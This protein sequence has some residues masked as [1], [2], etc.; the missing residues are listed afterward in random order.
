MLNTIETFPD[1]IIAYLQQADQ[2]PVKLSKIAVDLGAE[3]KLVEFWAEF[4]EAQGLLSIDYP[5]NVMASPKVSLIVKNQEEDER[6]VEP[7]ENKSLVQEYTIDCD[8]LQSQ[9]MI[10]KS[11]SQDVSQYQLITPQLGIGTRAL[12]DGLV[13]RLT[14]T[15]SV[16]L[17]EATDPKKIQKLK[18]DYFDLILSLLKETLPEENQAV[19]DALASILYHRV[20]GLGIID[21]ILSDDYIEEIAINSSNETISLYHKLQ[22]WLKTL[23]Y[24]PTEDKIF[25]ISSQIGRKSGQQINSLNPIM[26]AHL[27]TGDRVASTIY[28]ISTHGNTITIRRFSREPWTI[29]QFI[30]PKINLMSKRMASF[31]WLA[32]QYELNIIIAGGTASGKTSVLNAL[33]SLIPPTNRIISVEDTREISLPKSL[34]WNWVPMTSRNAN[35]EGKG[36]ISMLDLIIAALRMRPDRIIVGEIRKQDQAQALFEAMHTGHSVY[37]TMHADTS[38]QVIR[39]LLEPPIQVPETELASLHLVLI[40]FRDRRTGRRRTR[41]LVEILDSKK[42]VELNHLFRWNPRNDEF[43]EV[44]T[45][46]RVYE[47]ISLHVGMTPKEIEADLKERA[48]ILQWMLDSGVDSLHQ[49]GNV[50]SIYYKNKDF[51]VGCIKKKMGYDKVVDAYEEHISGHKPVKK[52]PPKPQ[53]KHEDEDDELIP[54]PTKSMFSKLMRKK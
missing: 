12:L 5:A 2:Q 51:L 3:A 48:S 28:P 4:L 7:A 8:K 34:Y 47:E 14:K 53:R 35:P 42:N 26:D 1:K 46:R 36:A 13:S 17:E 22:G 54:T 31:I 15:I 21:I 44:R 43:E 6:V 25:N 24:L 45:S 19:I 49:V 30:N 32:M 18:E 20:Q 10:W 52:K 29:T 50:L 11:A 33:S 38:T 39:R 16:E 40:Q 9:V 23:I 27:V 41:E 37:A